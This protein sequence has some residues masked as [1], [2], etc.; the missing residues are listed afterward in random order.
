VFATL[1]MVIAHLYSLWL[2][3]PFDLG[4]YALFAVLCGAAS[5]IAL[6]AVQRMAIPEASPTLP[7]AASLGVILQRDHRDSALPDDRQGDHHLFPDLHLV[8]QFG[9]PRDDPHP[10]FLVLA[11]QAAVAVSNAAAETHNADRTLRLHRDEDATTA[12]RGGRQDGRPAPRHVSAARMCL[13]LGLLALSAALVGCVVNSLLTG[14][15]AVA[16]MAAIGL[17]YLG[18]S[19]VAASQ[20]PSPL[21]EPV[22]DQGGSP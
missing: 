18:L 3:T 13:W 14:W 15:M 21:L 6:P 10:A 1:G 22:D 4:T 12:V 19:S 17:F 16:G 8:E 2:G 5:Y 11:R 20:A 9:F 7:L